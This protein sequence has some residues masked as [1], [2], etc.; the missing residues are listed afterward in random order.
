M[1]ATHRQR[2]LPLGAGASDPN[3]G[4]GVLLD[5]QFGG[6]SSRSWWSTSAWMV[7]GQLAI[8]AY[9]ISAFG[10]IF[11]FVQLPTKLGIA[12]ILMF[13]GIAF[14]LSPHGTF[15]RTVLSLPAVLL[16]LWWTLSYAWTPDIGVWVTVTMFQFAG[17]VLFVFAS[18]LPVERFMGA[19]IATTYTALVLSTVAFIVQPGQAMTHIDPLTGL[20]T[21][22]GWHGSF[23][24]KNEMVPTLMFGA[25]TI[26]LYQR[27][28][29]TRTVA[30]AYIALLL[31]MAQSSTG[32]SVVAGLLLFA[33]WL[34]RYTSQTSR[35]RGS[36]VM[37]SSLVTILLI[38][39]VVVL[40]P[41]IVGA[42][43]KDLTFSGRTRIWGAVLDSVAQ[44]PWTGYSPNGVWFDFTSSPTT[45]IFRAIGFPAT[46]SHNGALEM[47]LRLGVVGLVLFSMLLFA[48]AQGGWR[49]LRD[50][51]ALGTWVLMLCALIVLQSISEI[52][53]LGGWLNLLI[54]ARTLAIRRAAELDRG[55]TRAGAYLAYP[56]P[57]PA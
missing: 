31:V 8:V 6:R 30:L 18:V 28:S 52:A 33:W 47:L 29:R 56:V 32:I 11:E 43:G 20:Q 46:H 16:V 24:H 12:I 48:A 1:T 39:A 13:T 40:M 38:G 57:A 54:A 14:A 36:F 19:I 5:E 10:V 3:P 37:L 21:L 51:R 26:L 55:S 2:G 50:D 17:L 25:I 34:G 53:T 44:R 35:L 49:L 23:V 9:M 4:Q 22:P 27:K 15:N 7:F 45:D 41:L 42:Y